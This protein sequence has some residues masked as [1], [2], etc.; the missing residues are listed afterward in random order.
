MPMVSG[1]TTGRKAVRPA[2]KNLVVHRSFKF[3]NMTSYAYILVLNRSL[4][5]CDNVSDQFSLTASF[6]VNNIVKAAS[7]VKF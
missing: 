2:D 7:I 1:F 6:A 4:R 5:S 3:D